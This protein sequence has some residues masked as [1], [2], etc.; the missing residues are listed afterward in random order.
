MSRNTNCSTTAACLA[1]CLAGLPATALSQDFSERPV[2]LIVGVQPGGATDTIGRII[3]ARLTDRINQR[4]VVENRPGPSQM[5]GLEIVA[6]APPDGYTLFMSSSGISTINALYPKAP[7]DA[8]TDFEPIAFVATS[9]YILV[10]HPTLPVNTVAEFIDYG[11]KN[12]GKL[13]YSGGTPGT[14]Q[15]L[16]GELFKRST[17]VDMLYIMYKG[18]GALMPDLLGGRLQAAFE[19]VLIVIPHIRR[20]ALRGL[21]VTSLQRSPAIPELPTIAESGVPGFQATGWF[22]VFAPARTPQPIVKRLNAEIQAIMKTPEVADRLTAAGAEAVSAPPEELRSLLH[23]EIAVWHKVIRE[24]G[25][26]VQ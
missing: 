7:F 22:G 25:I 16:G 19:N 12:P 18:T 26:R 17:G 24:A 4:V 10:V 6:K 14:A 15:H 13:S 20:G 21:G 5:V 2:R 23:R 11:R 3:A 1:A 8:A 9:P